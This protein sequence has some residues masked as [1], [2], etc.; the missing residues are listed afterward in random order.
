[1]NRVC[2]FSLSYYWFWCFNILFYKRY[3]ILYMIY[4]NISIFIIDIN[5]L[6]ILILPIIE[7]VTIWISIQHSNSVLRYGMRFW[8]LDYKVPLFIGVTSCVWGLLLLIFKLYL[9]QLSYPA[10]RQE[11]LQTS[12]A[13]N[14]N[15]SSYISHRHPYQ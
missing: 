9:W 6:P 5:L 4:L 3:F 2:I 13:P 1:M 7:I 8:F 14:P 15:A 11:K 10:K 12:L